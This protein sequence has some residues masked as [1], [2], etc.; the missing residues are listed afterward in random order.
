MF[1]SGDES[2]TIPH[3]LKYN[4]ILLHVWEFTSYSFDAHTGGKE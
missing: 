2:I 1:V 4:R 3:P